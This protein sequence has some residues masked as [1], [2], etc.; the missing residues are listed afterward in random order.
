MAGRLSFIEIG[1]SDPQVASSF[2]G[3]LF[4]WPFTPMG[5]A[6]EGWF[7]RRECG[8]ACTKKRIRNSTSSS[9]SRTSPPRLIASSR[10]VATRKSLVPK[11]RALGNSA[12]AARRTDWNSGCTSPDNSS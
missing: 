4:D 11:N 10:W 12:I 6:G 5:D 9:M 7:R 2:L 1:T 8:R 3:Q